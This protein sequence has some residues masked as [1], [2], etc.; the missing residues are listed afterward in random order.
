METVVGISAFVIFGMWIVAGWKS[1]TMI[2]PNIFLIM[3]LVGWVIYFVI[4]GLIS[5]LLGIF[6]LPYRIAK[7]IISKL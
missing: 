6:I 4:K 2:Q 3:P 7:F 1:L 5:L